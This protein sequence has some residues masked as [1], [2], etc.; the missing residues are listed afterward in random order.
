M[1]IFL[2]RSQEHGTGEEKVTLA[3]TKDFTVAV[4]EISHVGL[5]S[6]VQERILRKKKKINLH[7]NI[8]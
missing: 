3:T 2:E 7:E 8:V 4:A 5:E 1:N 6:T